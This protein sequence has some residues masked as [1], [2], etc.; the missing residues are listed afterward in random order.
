MYFYRAFGKLLYLSVEKTHKNQVSLNIK[1]IVQLSSA[2]FFQKNR[3]GPFL[4]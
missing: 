1:S 3:R 2:V 4:M